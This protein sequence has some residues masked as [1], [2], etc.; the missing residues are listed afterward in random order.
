MP[1]FL[2]IPEQYRTA[3]G[4]P[5]FVD[6][7]ASLPIPQSA[8]RKLVQLWVLNTHV[9]LTPTEYGRVM[10]NPLPPQEA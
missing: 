4:R 7:L 1:S 2:D 3:E 8:K 10:T 5:G 6:W 9:M